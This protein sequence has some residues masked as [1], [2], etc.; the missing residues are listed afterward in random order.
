MIFKLYKE[1]LKSEIFSK[2]WMK[3]WAKRFI[4][5]PKLIYLIYIK[6]YYKL[7]GMKIG[8]FSILEGFSIEGRAENLVVGDCSF[9]AKSSKISAHNKVFI[10]NCVVIN[11]GVMVLTASHDVL[12]EKWKTISKPI[13]IKD[14][15]WI[16][17]RS[18]ILPGVVIGQ[19]AVVAAGSVVTKDVPP[20]SIVGGN[21]AIKLAK[22]RSA[23]LNYD[24][25]RLAAPIEAWLGNKL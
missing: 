11:S 22:N 20:Y 24:P 10:G 14:Y 4:S 3:C 9:I 8:N 17:S 7:K 15:A 1:R 6:E 13:I 21:P 25:V 5:F 12:D 23:N 18:I 2:F 19:G 16:A